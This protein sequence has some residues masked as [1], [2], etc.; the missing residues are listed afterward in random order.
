MAELKIRVGIKTDGRPV[1][2]EGEKCIILRNMLI[3]DSFHWQHSTEVRL[4]AD[5]TLE[6]VDRD[7]SLAY[8]E[9]DSKVTLVMTLPIESYLMSVVA[10][11]MKGSAP[12][13]FLKAHAVISRSWV[14]G[15]ITGRHPM[16]EKGKVDESDRLI[17]WDDTCGHKG[18]HVCSD[19]HCQRYEGMK[20]IAPSILEALGKTEGEVLTTPRGEVLDARF[21]KCCGGI[22]EVFETCWQPQ[23]FDCLESIR[24]PWCNL[25]NLDELKRHGI[26]ST[27]LNEYD[28]NT[29]GYGYRWES[30]ISKSDVRDN[31]LHKFGRDIGRIDRIIPVHRGLSGRIDLLRLEGEKGSLEIGKELWIRRLLSDSH[32]YSSCFE[33]EDKGESFIL[34]GRGWGHGVGLCQIGAANM[35]F[36]GYNYREILQYYYPGS[37][38]EKWDKLEGK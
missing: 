11:E 2:T 26:L 6:E 38:V 37:R 9:A 23:H 18:F 24:D 21:S 35:A 17:G 32:L 31:L 1:L 5:A 29:E 4:P 7:G 14:I 27:I 16:D 3:G 33:I 10:S 20:Q 12:V 15:K 28:L 36:H 19:D 13:E 25:E 8:G 34:R 22:S 30:E